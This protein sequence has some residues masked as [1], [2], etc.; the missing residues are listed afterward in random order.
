MGLL[1][2]ALFGHGSKP[3]LVNAAI[4]GLEHPRDFQSSFDLMLACGFR[5]SKGEECFSDYGNEKFQNNSHDT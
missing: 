5:L 3:V 1:T 2:T 4:L